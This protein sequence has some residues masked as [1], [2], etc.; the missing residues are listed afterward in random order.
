MPTQRLPF[1]RVLCFTTCIVF[2]GL[3]NADEAKTQRLQFVAEL[4][5]CLKILREYGPN[6]ESGNQR[7]Q[8]VLDQGW[9]A[10]LFPI[11]DSDQLGTDLCGQMDGEHGGM[12]FAGRFRWPENL[13]PPQPLKLSMFTTAWL[14][15]ILKR[16]QAASHPGQS[17]DR[18]V[19]SKLPEPKAILV[20]VFFQPLEAQA[21]AP[22]SI[23]L[24]ADAQVIL[25]ETRVPD[26]LVRVTETE[27]ASKNA[28]EAAPQLEVDDP[29]STDPKQ[30]LRRLWQ[31]T[32][33]PPNAIILRVLFSDSEAILE[34][35]D[36]PKST[37][38]AARRTRYTN[39]E[40]NAEDTIHE[41]PSTWQACAMSRAQVQAAI[42][43]VVHQ[44]A[45]QK[46]APRLKYL[47]LECIKE[48]PKPYWRLI[49]LEPFEYFDLP[50]KL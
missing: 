9:T 2:C 3:V 45:Y 25:R 44:A 13:G 8:L 42:D 39:G 21:E 16:A 48:T 41:W 30:A 19:I 23:D 12:R 35:L 46:A 29:P 10:S 17:I 27:A 31:F 1:Q 18:V 34:Y 22:L 11:A 32:K 26:Q 40:A 24:N 33:A 49:I 38:Q 5:D 43:D 20:R 28:P 4:K 14:D 47:T 6:T 7:Y 36:K 50:A 37:L 15:Q